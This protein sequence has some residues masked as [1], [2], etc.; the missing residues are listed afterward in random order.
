[1]SSDKFVDRH[2]GPG[3]LDVAHM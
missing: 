2:I 3:N 1:M